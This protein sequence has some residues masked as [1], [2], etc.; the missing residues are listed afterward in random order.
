MV[1]ACNN[2][3]TGCSFIKHRLPSFTVVPARTGFGLLSFMKRH[4]YS[5]HVVFSILSGHPVV[6]VASQAKEEQ[7]R[8]TIVALTFFVANTGRCV[9]WLAV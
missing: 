7:L 2:I 4:D 3:I 8:A 5:Q 1:V 9:W 6:V